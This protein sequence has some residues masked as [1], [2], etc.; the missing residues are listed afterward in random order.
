MHTPLCRH[1]HG[2]PEEYAAAA[3]IAYA[4]EPMSPNMP[5]QPGDEE[6]CRRAL[7][8]AYD[9]VLTQ[10]SQGRAVMVH[11]HAGKDRTGLILSYFLMKHAGLTPVDAI[12]SVRRVRRAGLR[13]RAG[14]GVRP[15]CTCF[16]CRSTSFSW[17]GKPD[18]SGGLYR[19]RRAVPSFAGAAPEA[20]G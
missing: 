18:P 19:N 14:T 16:R 3:D 9:F 7:L 13:M 5:P 4:C 2:A 17:P 1:A 15:S 8:R 6:G 11:C 12:R 20:G 10:M